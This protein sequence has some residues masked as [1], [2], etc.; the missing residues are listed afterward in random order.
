MKNKKYIFYITLLVLASCNIFLP[1]PF[2]IK[3]HENQDLFPI[4]KGNSWEYECVNS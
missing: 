3:P 4:N 2:I 1:S